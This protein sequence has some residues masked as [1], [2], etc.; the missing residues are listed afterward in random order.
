MSN[1]AIFTGVRR[2]RPDYRD[3][4]VALSGQ[5]YA[6]LRRH[7]IQEMPHNLSPRRWVDIENDILW[8]TFYDQD[9]RKN[10]CNLQANESYEFA[11]YVAMLCDAAPL[12]SYICER[13]IR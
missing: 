8:A 11:P 2:R 10:T 7:I 9:N 13:P 3:A 5:A 4:H 12:C 1:I 6:I